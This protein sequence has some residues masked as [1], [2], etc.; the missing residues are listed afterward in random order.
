M[1]VTPQ[2]AGSPPGPPPTV[3]ARIRIDH[4][5]A[6]HL[7]AATA[8]Q[9]AL[10]SGLPG[11]LPDRAAVLASELASNIAKHA[12]EGSV[13]VQ[14]LPLRPG[15]EILASDR[16]PGIP[17]L[18]AAFTDGWT[19]TNTLG[20]GLGAVRRIASEFTLRTNPGTGTVICARLTAPG[21]PAARGPDLAALCL[22]RESE[23][24]CGDGWAVSDTGDVATDLPQRTV[25]VVDGLGHGPPAAEAADTA[26]RAFRRDPDLPL[27]ALMTSLHK[28]LRRTRGAAV[29]LLRLRPDG[30]AD[31]CSVGN[32]RAQAVGF[33][34]VR[35][36]LS[37]QP[38]VVGWNMPLPRVQRIPVPPG[39]LLVLH[40]DGVDPRWTHD[41]TRFLLRLPP[42]LLVA[43]LAHD[44]R[45][46]RDDATVLATGA[47]VPPPD[48]R[49]GGG[50]RTG[51]P[52]PGSPEPSSPKR[53]A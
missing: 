14:S 15:V 47:L 40:S 7:A 53:D 2:P 5:S 13:F 8:R 28:S 25:V 30:H 34:G 23:D 39:S 41:P 9:I 31:H 29:G 21:A 48:A 38:G 16:G 45:R 36:R 17:D 43:S 1:S 4:Y 52:L 51:S 37:G 50:S 19:T 22:P 42:P 3:A 20:S 33:D 27:P 18:E 26:L 35:S 49:P 6:V 32:V 12:Q 10:D 24:S 46:S 44:F 11:A